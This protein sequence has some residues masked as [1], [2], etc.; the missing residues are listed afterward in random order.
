M[1]IKEIVKI[2]GKD[3]QKHY[4]DNNKTIRKVGTNEEYTEA[5][6]L[7]DKNWQYEETENNIIEEIE[8]KEDYA[9]K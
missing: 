4:S 7:L 5:I 2:N 1:V 6:D 9:N 3:F 8:N